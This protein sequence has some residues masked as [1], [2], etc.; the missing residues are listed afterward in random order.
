MPAK[1]NFDG[2]PL[3]FGAGRGLSGEAE[4]VNRKN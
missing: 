4:G 2:Q 3:A 1:I